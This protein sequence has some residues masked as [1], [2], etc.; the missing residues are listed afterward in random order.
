MAG[1]GAP[2]GGLEGSMLVALVSTILGPENRVDEGESVESEIVHTIVEHIN[3]HL[4]H[5]FLAND[6]EVHLRKV[7]SQIKVVSELMEMEFFST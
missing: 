4:Q 1:G 2:G 7:P 3:F 6:I 5:Q